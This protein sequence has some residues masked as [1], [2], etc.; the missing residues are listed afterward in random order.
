M[1]TSSRL[2]PVLALSLLLGS[3]LAG[4]TDGG[5]GGDG[6]SAL[7]SEEAR[8]EVQ[9]ALDTLESNTSDYD[10]KVAVNA[11]FTN[12]TGGETQKGYMD[13][14]LDA[15]LNEVILRMAGQ[16]FSGSG[17]SGASFGY[18]VMGRLGQ[19]LVF[20]ADDSVLSAYN[21]TSAQVTSFDSLDE[22]NPGTPGAAQSNPTFL[23]EALQKNLTRNVDEF[24]A[25]DITYQGEEALEIRS[26]GDE[27]TGTSLRVVLWKEPK[28]PALIEGR[29]T[30]EAAENN[31][32]LQG[33]GEIEM[34]IQYGDDASLE[35]RDDL[36]RVET[37]T[38]R[39]QSDSTPR[40]D[41]GRWTNHTI[42]P[43]RDL[44]EG[45]VDLAEVT[46]IVTNQ[47][48]GGEGDE[49]LT[50]S[51]DEGSAET[52]EARLTYADADEDGAVSEGD[53]IRLERLDENAS[54]SLELEDTVTGLKVTPS[55]PLLASLAAAVGAALVLVRRP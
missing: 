45:E 26:A 11:T 22:L 20:G 2:V 5:L 33:A 13:M 16:G 51:L 42:Q 43:S 25:E 48:F 19:T 31:A 24:T 39:S 23:F 41:Q 1:S 18:L 28:R 32:N 40:Q 35:I 30:E 55:A 47:T 37:L 54:L 29:V 15:E 52:D 17:S 12:E 9:T 49:V 14:Y 36:L 50:M 53:E 27:E 46:A 10:S 7:T 44:P 38:F 6:G 34:V 3:A 21:D 4:C 8:A